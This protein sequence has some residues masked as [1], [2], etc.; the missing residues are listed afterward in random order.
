MIGYA[1]HISLLLY[2]KLFKYFKYLFIFIYDKV[3]ITAALS[4]FNPDS[5]TYNHVLFY[6]TFSVI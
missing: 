2:C 6:F 4:C 3:S 5:D 1:R